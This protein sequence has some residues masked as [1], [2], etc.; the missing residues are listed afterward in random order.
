MYG[1]LDNETL[2]LKNKFKNME[3]WSTH[4]RCL[5]WML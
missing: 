1:E 4:S 5:P 2:Q 3:K